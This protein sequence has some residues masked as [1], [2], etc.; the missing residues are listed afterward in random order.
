M[1]N[2]M[3]SKIKSII[4]IR[5]PFLLPVFRRLRIFFSFK[6]IKMSKPVKFVISRGVGFNICKGTAGFFEYHSDGSKE[7]EV[8]EEMQAFLKLTGNKNFLLDIGALYGVFSLVFTCNNPKKIAYAIEP[9]PEPFQVLKRH[10]KINPKLHIKPFKIAM[11]SHEGKLRMKYEW[12]HLVVISKDEVLPNSVE[13]K[14]VKLDDFVKTNNI[15][16]DVLK[17]D[18]EGS[19]FYI[20]EGGK[21]F[22]KKYGPL[23]HLEVHAE[24][25]KKLDVSI[26][27][28]VDLLHSLEYKIYDLKFNLIKDPVF[29]LSN[30]PYC[31]VICNK[32]LPG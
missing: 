2:K 1:F 14:V 16:P 3:F 11:G 25:L 9:S 19:E 29:V 5:A 10:I 18:T 4:K 21:N 23:I 32:K 30:K 22:L 20:L 28:L 6:E 31:R 8:F 26:E 24:W 27:Q 15:F 13:A 7:N 12:Q 17:I